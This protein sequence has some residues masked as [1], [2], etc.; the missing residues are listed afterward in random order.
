MRCEGAFWEK[1]SFYVPLW[2]PLWTPRQLLTCFPIVLKNI[3]PNSVTPFKMQGWSPIVTREVHWKKNKNKCFYVAFWKLWQS[4]CITYNTA[5]LGGV[6][7]DENCL[8]ALVLCVHFV[9]YT[10]S[11]LHSLAYFIRPNH[12]S[13][14][15]ASVPLV[16]AASVPWKALFTSPSHWFHWQS[17][18]AH[19]RG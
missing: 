4:K 9:V 16:R 18:E 5:E 8:C 15:S 2:N 14:F 6:F 12:N 17:C 11:I 3:Y 10:A 19:H 7:M 13:L 1:S